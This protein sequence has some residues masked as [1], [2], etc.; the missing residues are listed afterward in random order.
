MKKLLALFGIKKKSDFKRYMEM[1]RDM[2]IIC[3]KDKE[4]G[5]HHAAKAAFQSAMSYRAA[6][7]A[8]AYYNSKVSK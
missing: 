4:S 8:S 6:A 5:F 1:A 3:K 2:L 7:H